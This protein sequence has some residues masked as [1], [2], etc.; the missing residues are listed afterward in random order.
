[1][2]TFDAVNT[3]P[4]FSGQLIE[5]DALVN[6]ASPCVYATLQIMQVLKSMPLQKCDDLQT[7]RAVMTN[8]DRGMR[9]VYLIDEIWNGLH[10]AQLAT[11]NMGQL[12]F[13]WFAN[14]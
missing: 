10:W 1:M 3:L 13:P 8:Y 11:F 12:K 4:G 5:G 14:V 6:L 7:S 2:R 9:L